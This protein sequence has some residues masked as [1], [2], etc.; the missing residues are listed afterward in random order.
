M[1]EGQR[2]DQLIVQLRTTQERQRGQKRAQNTVRE[3][4]LH[5]QFEAELAMHQHA[6]E[7]AIAASRRR[8]KELAAPAHALR[9]AEQQSQAEEAQTAAQRKLASLQSLKT[10]MDIAAQDDKR[11]AIAHRK[12]V[13]RDQARQQQEAAELL[14][15]GENP[16]LVF[17][18]RAIEEERRKRAA[19]EAQRRQQQCGVVAERLQAE[20]SARRQD[21]QERGQ[22]LRAAMLAGTASSMHHTIV[23]RQGPKAP[24]NPAMLGPAGTR[25]TLK[26]QVQPT[27]ATRS[28][29]HESMAGDSLADD[30]YEAQD[31]YLESAGSDRHSL[32]GPG[33]SDDGDDDERWSENGLTAMETTVKRRAMKQQAALIPDVEAQV[34]SQQCKCG[35]GC[36]GNRA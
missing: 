15:Q 27:I 12:F 10:A 20:A 22:R 14:A 35:A 13:A 9:K 28:S 19:V 5:A 18:L 36:T 11:R 29:H 3:G 7:E 32:P 30:D 21:M 6:T 8:G 2:A 25:K 23:A 17:K 4:Q 34:G 24:R 26:L 1:A 33:D 16:E 31:P